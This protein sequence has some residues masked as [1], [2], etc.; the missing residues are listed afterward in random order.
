MRNGVMLHIVSGRPNAA[1]N[2]KWDHFA[3]ACSNLDEMI[4]RLQ[5]KNIAWSDID[6]NPKPQ[7]RADGVRQIF[8]R[9]PDGYWI[10]IND[11]LKL[12]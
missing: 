5:A 9:D 11:S 4:A 1:N 2:S 7:Q 3:V 6:G 8:I 12:R 10:E